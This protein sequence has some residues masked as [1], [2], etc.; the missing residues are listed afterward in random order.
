MHLDAL[1]LRVLPIRISTNVRVR[2]ERG[3]STT[4]GNNLLRCGD[5]GLHPVVEIGPQSIGC[6]AI[7][8]VE[9]VIP[10]PAP[11]GLAIEELPH[12]GSTI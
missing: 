4:D 10:W 12:Y 7:P 6:H 9:A 11:E 8:K 1:S 3:D 5:T 2:I